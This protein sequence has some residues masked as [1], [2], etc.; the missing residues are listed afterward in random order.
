MLAQLV[1]AVG[2]TSAGYHAACGPFMHAGH[3]S[4]PVDSLAACCVPSQVQACCLA[5]AP[6]QS[7]QLP[8]ELGWGMQ[9]IWQSAA[10][11]KTP[12]HRQSDKI[13]TCREY[14]LGRCSCLAACRACVA[15]SRCSRWSP[16]LNMALSMTALMLQRSCGRRL[17]NR[18][19][20]R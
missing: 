12:D 5:T 6:S 15:C 18:A 8:T 13:S 3:L 1:S 17:Q 14:W 10:P 9:T 2:R 11:P 16:V 4:S 20:Q 19:A 7:I